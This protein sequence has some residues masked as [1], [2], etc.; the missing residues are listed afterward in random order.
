MPSLP[1]VLGLIPNTT[2]MKESQSQACWLT[3]VISGTCE[4]EA[5]AF[6]FWEF[7]ANL[8]E[9]MRSYFFKMKQQLK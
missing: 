1:K 9:I 7:E 6:Q 8:D 2:K 5:G 3:P 4:A